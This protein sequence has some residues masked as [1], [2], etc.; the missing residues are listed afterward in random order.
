MRKTNKE[1]IN[2]IENT[3]YLATLEVKEAI[4]DIKTA[5]KFRYISQAHEFYKKWREEYLNDITRW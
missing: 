5:Y 4:R 2:R 1:R 3:N